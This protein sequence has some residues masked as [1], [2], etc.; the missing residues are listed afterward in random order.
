M[1]N[2]IKMKT[3]L[4][5][6]ICSLF[7]CSKKNDFD[8]VIADSY[9]QSEKKNEYYIDFSSLMW[10]EWDTMCFYSGANSLEDIEKDLGFTYSEWGDVGDRVIF[11]KNGKIV[12]QKEWFPRVDQPLR[13]AVFIIE[14]KK[15]K[16]PKSD[17]KFKIRKDGQAFYLEKY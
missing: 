2:S 4:L 7:S 3:L 14:L 1:V 9:R 12:Y 15:F 10:F 16:L 17:A 8:N 6:I 11:L 5:G 13:G